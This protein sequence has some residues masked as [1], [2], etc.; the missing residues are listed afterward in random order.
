MDS[1]YPKITNGRRQKETVP[2]LN[3]VKEGSSVACWIQVLQKRQEG[4]VQVL[5]KAKEAM[6]EPQ[7]SPGSP[8]V[9]PAASLSSYSCFCFILLLSC[10]CYCHQGCHTCHFIVVVVVIYICCYIYLTRHQS[11]QLARQGS[12]CG[13][14]THVS[15]HCVCLLP[16]CRCHDLCLFEQTKSNHASHHPVC[17]P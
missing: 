1:L 9:L 2:V 15:H 10:Y 6:W 11:D 13:S 5:N 12:V 7:L 16:P 4:T 17:P 3:E 14:S 8:H